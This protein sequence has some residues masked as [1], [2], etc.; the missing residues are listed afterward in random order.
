MGLEPV[1]ELTT[2]T[3]VRRVCV[4]VHLHVSVCL[5]CG[6]ARLEKSYRK[7]DVNLKL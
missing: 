5:D 2:T 1:A 4:R 3:L 7:A 6:I